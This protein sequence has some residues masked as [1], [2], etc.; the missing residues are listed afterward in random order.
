M[1]KKKIANS[2]KVKMPNRDGSEYTL[3]KKLHKISR[4]IN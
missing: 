2:F 3:E 1:I 4:S